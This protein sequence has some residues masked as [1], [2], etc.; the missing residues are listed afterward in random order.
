MGSN[1]IIE[2]CPR[3]K[4]LPLRLTSSVVSD[5]HSAYY[6]WE[7]INLLS[8]IERRTNNFGSTSAM[9]VRDKRGCYEIQDHQG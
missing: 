4:L 7:F 1:G 9:G 3:Y 8:V 6:W 2:G 5:I